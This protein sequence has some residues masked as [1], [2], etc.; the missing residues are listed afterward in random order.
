MVRDVLEIPIVGTVP[1]IKPAAALTKTGQIGLLGTEATIRQRY[2]D[3][4]EAA[5]AADKNLIRYA[6][7]ALVDLAEAKLRGATLD[8]GAVAS[9]ISGLINHEKGS[10]IDTIVLACTHFPLLEA[11]LALNLP[12]GVR[13]VD[14]AQGI[15]RRVADLTKDQEFARTQDNFAVVT[16]LFAQA[17]LASLASAL[18][19]YG[20]REIRQ[21]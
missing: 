12:D 15:A 11:E 13:F 14:G 9:A 17:E 21:L 18:Q 6:A 5:F 19:H 10:E 4:L 3:N 7:P 2:V 20:I 16:K 1:A 8:P